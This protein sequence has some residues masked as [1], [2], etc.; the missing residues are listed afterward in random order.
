MQAGMKTEA[1]RTKTI[2]RATYDEQVTYVKKWR[3]DARAELKFSR[4]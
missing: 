3:R 2:D 1:C 4:V